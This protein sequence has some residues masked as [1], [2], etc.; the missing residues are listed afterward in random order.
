MQDL[1]KIAANGSGW[2][3]LSKYVITVLQKLADSVD[4]NEKDLASFREKLI[5]DLQALRE[6]V[7]FELSGCQNKHEGGLEKAL[8]NIDSLIRGL[9]DRTHTLEKVNF[10]F[11]IDKKIAVLKEDIIIP[12]RLKMAIL[13]TFAGACGGILMLFLANFL[14]TL[15]AGA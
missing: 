15:F 1:S 9:S 7:R 12:L 11:I 8:D 10:E 13:S 2:Q 4:E 6:S 14:K 3:E 5:L